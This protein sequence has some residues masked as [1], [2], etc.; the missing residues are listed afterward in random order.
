[1]NYPYGEQNSKGRIPLRGKGV[2]G[3]TRTITN[4][5]RDIQGLVYHP[6]KEAGF[7]NTLLRADPVYHPPP[8]PRSRTRR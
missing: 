3:F 7:D 4:Q 8:P 1:M 5:H 2:A 6:Y